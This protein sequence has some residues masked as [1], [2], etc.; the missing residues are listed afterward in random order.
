MMSKHV[1]LGRIEVILL[2]LVVF[3]PGL[4]A[5]IFV[6]ALPHPRLGQRNMAM[7][8][9]LAAL[10]ILVVL[11]VHRANKAWSART[12]RQ[13]APKIGR[14]PTADGGEVGLR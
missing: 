4:S 3:C 9:I 6:A 8:L 1:P 14:P 12:A 13:T 10:A 7:A 11:N 2:L 5:G